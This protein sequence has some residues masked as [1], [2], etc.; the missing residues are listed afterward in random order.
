MKHQPS[1]QSGY[2][3]VEL[4][5]GLVISLFVTGV[6]ITYL[7]SSS[8]LMATQS[9]EDV[10]Q[11]NARFAFEMISSN[12]RIAGYNPSNNFQTKNKVLGLVAA[13]E[14]DF[15]SGK[16]AC[17]QDAKNYSLD[18][19]TR[20]SDTLAFN[21]ILFSGTTCTGESINS[22]MGVITSYYVKENNGVASLYC[23][24]YQKQFDPV[25]NEFANFPNPAGGEVP[26]IDGIDSL[27][28][29]YGLDTDG[30]ENV[31]T[32]RDFNGVGAS[33]IK[34]IRVGLL[35]SAGQTIASEQNT[36]ID[37]TTRTYNVLDSTLEYDDGVPRQ[38][39]TTTIFLPNMQGSS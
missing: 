38:I 21:Y 11:E 20:S 28:V 31:D 22:E 23:S 7:V 13:V 3:L 36:L 39:L 8:R 5:V 26:L 29:Q 6:A 4:L 16:E 17:T 19:V 33:E 37:R 34:T 27:Q 9:S 2:T 32:Y 12:A 35:V 15:G 18:G 24:A 10:I 30:D 1:L 14:C 25:T